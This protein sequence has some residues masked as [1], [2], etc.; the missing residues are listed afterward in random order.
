MQRPAL[1]LAALLA[2]ACTDTTGGPDP[3]DPSDDPF[4]AQADTSEGLTNVSADLDAVLEH[5]ALATA[6]ADAAARPTDRR[7][8]LLCGKAM[9]FDESFGTPG[10]PRPIL[11]WL[12]QHFP[13]Q[14]GPGFAQRRK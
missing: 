2:A 9:F 12:V 13:E 11:A 6:C 4:A 7:L 14:V 1:A 3:T 5:G 10:I 8:R